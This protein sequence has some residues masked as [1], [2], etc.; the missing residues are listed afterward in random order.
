MLKKTIFTAVVFISVLSLSLLWYSALR[1]FDDHSQRE[2]IL[3]FRKYAIDAYMHLG[4]G[5]YSE[6]KEL[7]EKAYALHSKDVKTLNDMA[8]VYIKLN[9]HDEAKKLFAY[10]IE[11]DPDAYDARYN[12]A[13]YLHSSGEHEA[14]N[15]ILKELLHRDRRY[16]KYIKLIA[17]N[18]EKLA[19]VETALTYYAKLYE[20]DANK[21]SKDKG[22]ATLAELYDKRLHKPKAADLSFCYEKTDDVD[23]L[24]KIAKEY[25]SEGYDFKAVMTYRKI[26]SLL[27]YIDQDIATSLADL[28]MK[29][30]SYDFALEFVSMLDGEG[31]ELFL[32]KGRFYHA[33][34]R[35]DKALEYYEKALDYDENT[36]LYHKLTAVSFQ[37]KEIEKAKY[38]HEKLQERDPL[39]AH[40]LMHAMLISSGKEFGKMESLKYEALAIYYALFSKNS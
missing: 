24:K 17:I 32:K 31:Y 3:K 12:Y 16:D 21:F 39:L 11:L 27:P 8:Q 36:F 28:Y 14:S 13:V 10:I 2:E 19:D 20:I 23:M 33:A 29:Y 25:E 35:Y 34:K 7:Y 4:R 5:E 26:L 37:S 30:G 18:Y 15:K 1:V 40:K 22:L 6:A 38:Y 9:M